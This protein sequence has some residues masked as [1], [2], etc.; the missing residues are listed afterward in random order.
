MLT[1]VVL[2]GRFSA[3]VE[4]ELQHVKLMLLGSVDFSSFTSGRQSQVTTSKRGTCVGNGCGTCPAQKRLAVDTWE[5]TSSKQLCLS[6]LVSSRVSSG[7][8]SRLEAE[9]SSPD[10]GTR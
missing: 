9:R 2:P 3:Y 4:G 5:P 7:L 8:M 1:S 10:R 6:R